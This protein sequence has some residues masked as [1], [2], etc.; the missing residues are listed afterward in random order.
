MPSSIIALIGL[1][2]FP[3]TVR[4]SSG[5]NILFPFFCLSRLSTA[6]FGLLKPPP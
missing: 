3:K 5:V 1:L 2:A 4:I 6:A